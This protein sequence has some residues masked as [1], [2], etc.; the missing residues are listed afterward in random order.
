VPNYWVMAGIFGEELSF[1]IGDRTSN[2]VR[3]VAVRVDDDDDDGD[4]ASSPSQSAKRKE[5]LFGQDQVSTI[6]RLGATAGEFML[7]DWGR[8][9]KDRT[10]GSTRQ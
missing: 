6:G 1:S 7:D 9:K 8:Q 2:V 10:C 4:K 5:E 3:N